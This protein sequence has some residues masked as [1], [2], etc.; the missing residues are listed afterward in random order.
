LCRR[1]YRQ[2]QERTAPV[3]QCDGHFVPDY[4]WSANLD[5]S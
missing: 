5:V 4:G 3:T 1:N 2:L